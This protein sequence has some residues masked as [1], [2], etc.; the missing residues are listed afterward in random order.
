MVLVEQF[1]E[2]PVL[3]FTSRYNEMLNMGVGGNRWFLPAQTVNSC[4]GDDL[5]PPMPSNGSPQYQLHLRPAV[6]HDHHGDPRLH[7]V[8]YI[9]DGR[10]IVIPGGDA[11]AGAG[12]G[13][14]PGVSPLPPPG[15]VPM[16]PGAVI[17]R[18]VIRAPIRA[19]PL[20]APDPLPDLPKK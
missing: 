17:R 6:G 9:D 20:P 8:H 15:F 14:G 3:I 18:P 16:G 12:P 5:G 19:I 10:K 7:L 2:M 1:E 13:A 11:T 4:T